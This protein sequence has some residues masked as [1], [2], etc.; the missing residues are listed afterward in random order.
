M[1]FTFEGVETI[2][3]FKFKSKKL[4]LDFQLTRKEERQME[5]TVNLSLEEFRLLQQS[6]SPLETMLAKK[7]FEEARLTEVK[8]QKLL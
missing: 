4:G 3:I 8:E 5:I 6:K 7:I 1:S 2:H